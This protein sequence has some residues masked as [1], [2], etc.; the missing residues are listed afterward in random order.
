[1]RRSLIL[2]TLAVLLALPGTVRAGTCGSI[3]VSRDPTHPLRQVCVTDPNP[4]SNTACEQSGTTCFYI[5][6]VP[7]IAE[8]ER[9]PAGLELAFAAA[10]AKICPGSVERGLDFTAD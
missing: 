9:G 8:Q 1:M 4:N 2:G 3:C 7:N 5:H 6:C 10:S